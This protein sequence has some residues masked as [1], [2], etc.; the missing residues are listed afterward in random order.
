MYL[1]DH[2]MDFTKFGMYALFIYGELEGHRDTKL[3][4][5]SIHVVQ[6]LLQKFNPNPSDGGA[7]T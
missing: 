4:T 7:I 5:L 6:M 2:W 1:K 3:G